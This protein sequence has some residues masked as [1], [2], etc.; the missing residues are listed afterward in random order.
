MKKIVPR[1]I[2]LSLSLFIVFNFGCANNKL[3]K[4]EAK[5]III[6][7]FKY[8]QPAEEKLMIGVA[9]GLRED[10]LQEKSIYENLAKEGLIEMKPLKLGQFYEVSLTEKGK[11]YLVEEEGQKKVR[12]VRVKVA[13]KQFV[14]VTRISFSEEKTEAAV[15]FTWKY[16]NITPFGKHLKEPNRVSEAKFDESTLHTEKVILLQHADG[17]KVKEKQTP[18]IAKNNDE[19]NSSHD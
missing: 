17:W 18:D 3:K 11:Q 16:V 9:I 12:L 4:D 13:E 7:H 14:K 1:F 15:S 6:K 5:N 19:K 10:N 8:P 2:L